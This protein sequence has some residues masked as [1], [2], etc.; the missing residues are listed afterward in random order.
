MAR[1]AIEGDMPAVPAACRNFEAT[2]SPS[3]FVVIEVSA[4]ST[5]LGNT[6]A[7]H[8]LV[9]YHRVDLVRAEYFR[10]VLKLLKSRPTFW[11]H[12]VPPHSRPLAN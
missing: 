6:C 8:G 9:V 11:L 2:T 3:E 5:G 7:A 4:K 1:R 10:L 12:S